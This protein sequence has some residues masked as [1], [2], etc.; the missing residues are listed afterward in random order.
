M[1]ERHIRESVIAGSW[2]PGDPGKLTKDIEDYLQRVPIQKL[3]GELVALIVPHAGYMYSGQVAAYSYKLLQDQHYDLAVIVAPSHRAYFRGASVYPKGG[4][5]T[6]LGVVPIAE[7]LAEELIQK[8][9]FI[10]YVSQAHA[11]EHSLEIQIPFLQVVLKDFRLVPIVMGEQDFYACEEVSKAIV[12]VI[13][14]KN[15]IMIAS[16]DLS[17]FHPYTRAVELDQVVLD[18]VNSFDP[19]GLSKELKK[20]QC[21]ACGG[22]P[23]V[24]VMLA[25]RALGANAGKVLKY[26]NSGDVTGDRSSVV[27]YMAAALYRSGNPEEGKQKEKVGVDLGLTEKEQET[28]HGI[29]RTVIWNRASGK[30]VPEFT[31]QSERLKELRGAFVSLHKQEAL[32]G[33]IG[34]IR[35]IKPLYKAVQEMAEAAAF[36]D[37]RFPPVTEEELKDLDIEISVLTPLSQIDDVSQIQVGTHGI[38]IEKGFSSG[39]LLPQVATEYDWDRETFL[40]QT[41]IKAGLSR[42]AWK[43]KDTKIYIF[44]ADIF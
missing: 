9:P 24:T 37:P 11:Q 19:E 27:G 32:R 18:R 14:G 2:Y 4:Y 16:T 43:D 15:A 39:L 21:E 20:G 31:V 42:H 12:D 36:K 10:S 33:C 25:T 38:F 44:S 22:G 3:D 17:H 23:T 30:E 35:G 34:Y 28:L 1:S 5:R 7:D 6:P 40:E 13:R 8:N 26:A 29:A 41:C